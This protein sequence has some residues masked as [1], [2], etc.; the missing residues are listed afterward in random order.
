MS[1]QAL[2][3]PAAGTVS[4][5]AG[6]FGKVVMLG[7]FAH[8]RLPTTFIEP[9]DRWLS[10]CITASRVQLGSRWL[11]TYL[12]GPLWRFAWAPGVIDERWWFGVLMPSVDAVGRYFPLIVAGSDQNPPMSAAALELLDRWYAHA[13][14]AALQTLQ[15]G[16]TL[17]GFEAALS[18]APDWRRPA[19]PAEVQTH[20]NRRR[21][22]SQ[23]RGDCADWAR[24]LAAPLVEAHQRGHSLW[25]PAEAD[26]GP[27]AQRSLTVVSGLPDPDQF[28]L[29]LEGRW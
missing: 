23:G 22:V 15:G 27:A 7:D 4:S 18:T 9:C 17:A 24:T 5:T 8:R 26:V 10:Q 20:G 14:D 11:D 25:T 6:W 1:R 16:A 2:S 19:P 29:M 13:G 3:G 12:T 21:I 28:S